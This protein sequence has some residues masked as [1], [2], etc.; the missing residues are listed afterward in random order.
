MTWINT[1]LNNT[2]LTN[3]SYTVTISSLSAS[4]IYEYRAYFIA[5]GNPYYG[6]IRTGTTANI[7]YTPPT[8]VTGDVDLIGTTAMRIESNFVNAN[9]GAPILEYGLLYS[10]A[11]IYPLTYE[12]S[13]SHP[14]TVKKIS[15]LSDASPLPFQYSN[16]ITGL[17]SN[18]RTY[19]RAFAKNASVIGYGST[20]NEM[21]SED[22]VPPPPP[23]S[24]TIAVATSV[25]A[26]ET[27]K[28]KGS[29][30]VYCSITNQVVPNKLI[31]ISTITQS[32]DTIW[33]VDCEG[34][35]YVCF[36]GL[37][38]N[39]GV[40]NL[41]TQRNFLDTIKTNYVTTDNYIKGCTFTKSN[42]SAGQYNISICLCS[43]ML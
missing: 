2:P 18:T 11:N 37:N 19:F 12:N 42:T 43:G 27:L 24:T 13:V 33:Q 36:G 22:I 39:D 6:N 32:Y 17:H 1:P 3:N 29:Y 25:H 23:P 16:N 10:Q 14:L 4:T 8:V 5:N 34:S 30:G 41:L 35:Y 9:G 21:T 7:A 20:C 38:I 40:Q 15:V 28:F 26:D 31:T